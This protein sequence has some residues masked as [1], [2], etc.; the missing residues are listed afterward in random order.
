MEDTKNKEEK[1]QE[2]HMLSEKDKE[3]AIFWCAVL[4][5][6]LFR[7]LTK[8]EIN[9]H[10]LEISAKE[11]CFPSGI[12]KKPSFITLKRKLKKYQ[13]QGFEYLVRKRRSDIG[14]PRKV[15]ESVILSAVAA[16]EELAKRSDDNINVI[17]QNE[18][19]INIPK[20]TLYRHLKLHN[21]TKLKLGAMKEKVRCRW[22]RENPNELWIGD[23]SDGPCVIDANGLVVRAYLSLFIDCHSRFVVEGRYYIRENLSILIDSLLRA[24]SVHGASSALYLDNAKIYHAKALKAVCYALHIDLLHRTPS[25]PSPGGL[26]E[27]LFLTNQNQFETEVK[28][29]EILTLE[30]LNIGFQAWLHHYHNKEHSALKST[31]KEAYQR[32][33]KRQVDMNA[34]IK[35]FMEEDIRVVHRTFSD[36]SINNRLY[37]V[38]PKYRGDKVIVRYDKFGDMTKVLI[39]SLNNC[40]LCTAHEYHRELSEQTI[41]NNS[42]NTYVP[43]KPKYNYVDIII[44]DHKKYLEKTASKLDLATITKNRKWSFTAMIK[45]MAELL[46]KTIS[47][48]L[49]S[50]IEQLKKIY[51]LHPDINYSLLHLA[52]EKAEVKNINNIALQL[53]LLKTNNKKGN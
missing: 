53:Q 47:N 35:F 4:Q 5:P 23:F 8:S 52:Y 48:F 2:E 11:V 1:K 43:K 15:P 36:V 41:K 19:V 6:V 18:H 25:D 22:T 40:F 39:Y 10:L 3:I 45:T 44:D 28:A 17:I 24:W 46:G 14:L 27:R 29:G 20:S 38:E 49:T 50:E 42:T 21:A 30:K 32:A 26:V 13:T 16:K 51:D 34:V 37:S 9:K 7:K 31:P 33:T 12:T